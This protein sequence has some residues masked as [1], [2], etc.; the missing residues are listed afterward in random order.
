MISTT[1]IDNQRPPTGS[2]L[3]TLNMQPRLPDVDSQC[4]DKGQRSL[5]EPGRVRTASEFLGELS[6][7]DHAWTAVS[8]FTFCCFLVAADGPASTS[9]YSIQDG[10]HLH[11]ALPLNE[12]RR[13]TGL[14]RRVSHG[15]GWPA[16]QRSSSTSTKLTFQRTRFRRWSSLKSSRTR[17]SVSK[18]KNESFF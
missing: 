7:I 11:I 15:R 18:L 16:T 17:M 3:L 14:Q 13:P 4:E 6:V 5:F 12:T 2:P 9:S 8:G 1:D 10:F